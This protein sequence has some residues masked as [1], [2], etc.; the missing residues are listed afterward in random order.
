MDDLYARA[1]NYF[2]DSAMIH[3]F[4]AQYYN[5][6]KSNFRIEQMHLTNAEVGLS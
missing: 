4:A 1:I 5:I 3:V 2:R 6:Y